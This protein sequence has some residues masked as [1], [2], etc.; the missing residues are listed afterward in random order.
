MP[1]SSYLLTELQQIVEI[2]RNKNSGD[3]AMNGIG[4]NLSS[5]P[6]PEEPGGPGLM[7]GLLRNLWAGIRIA[8]F[9]PV[10]RRQFAVTG[11]QALAF[12]GIAASLA[13]AHTM[14]SWQGFGA[15]EFALKSGWLKTLGASC[16]LLFVTAYCIS[17]L[18]RDP[19]GF[20]GFAVIAISSMTLPI[21]V[22][23]VL[24][25]GTVVLLPL[26]VH[27]GV[28]IWLAML[29]YLLL[30]LW[31]LGTMARA[32]RVTYHLSGMRPALLS[33]RLIGAFLAPGIY[34][35]WYPSADEV[36][37]SDVTD[38]TDAMPAGT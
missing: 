21:A 3:Q 10:G 15:L 4:E 31:C 36:F 1:I 6:P 25:A 11:H 14:A 35:G 32:I 23:I 27:A 8:Q 12:L 22:Y 29:P 20:S 7:D 26:A 30:F 37:T 2:V 19:Q 28:S 18:A 5:E 38:E 33:L 17:V 9:K 13:F 34:F 16:L 24:T